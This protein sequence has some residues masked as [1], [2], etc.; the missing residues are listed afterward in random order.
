V[1]DLPFGGEPARGAARGGCRTGG[2]GEHLADGGTDPVDLGQRRFPGPAAPLHRRGV[3]DP[4]GTGEVAAAPVGR[5]Q[6]EDMAGTFGDGHHVV[7]P[8]TDVGP[9]GVPAVQ[10]L[11][12][13]A[14]VQQQRPPRRAGRRPYRRGHRHGLGPTVRQPGERARVRHPARQAQRVGQP[15][16]PVRV[17]A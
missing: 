15:V 11:H 6:A 14:D 16:P 5:G 9:R 17:V 10:R 4:A 3:D 1:T 8:G 2:G 13:V 12:H 7:R